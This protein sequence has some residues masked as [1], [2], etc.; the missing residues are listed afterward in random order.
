[1]AA[2][3]KGSPGMCVVRS[4]A[5]DHENSPVHSSGARI[6][7]MLVMLFSAPCTAPCSSGGTAFEIR[8]WTAG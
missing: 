8:A 4:L 1:M 2:P 3:K 6:P 5:I 7:A